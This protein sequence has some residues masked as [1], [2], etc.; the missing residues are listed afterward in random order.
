MQ[1]DEYVVYYT[2]TCPS[3]TD[4]ETDRGRMNEHYI[5]TYRHTEQKHEV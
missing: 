2:D 5:Q 3:Q 1:T 4:A